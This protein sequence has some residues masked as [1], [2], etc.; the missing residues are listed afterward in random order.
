M[1][2]PIDRF[3]AVAHLRSLLHAAAR[4]VR[5]F[6]LICLVAGA[7]EPAQ[8]VTLHWLSHNAPALPT[9][10]S[11]GV[12]WPRG[13][14]SKNQAFTLTTASD[15]VLPLQSWTLAYWPDGSI[16][17]TG[18]ATCVPTGTTETL[19]LAPANQAA[20]ATPSEAAPAGPTVQV[21]ESATTYQIN[22][23]PLQAIIDKWGG[24]IVR[25]LSVNGHVVARNGRLVCIL[26]DGPADDPARAVSRQEYIS[27]VTKVTLEQSGPVRAVLKLAGVHQAEDGARQWLP[28]DV[29]LY[30]YA[31]QTT[32]RMVHT[33]TYDGNPQQD[34]IRGLAVTFAVPFR[35]ET[36][37]RQVRFSG[38]GMGL[39]SEPVQP[40]VGR[41]DHFVA[42]PGH[43]E[44]FNRREDYFPDQVAGKR[45]PNL[46]QFTE[47][48]NTAPT[49]YN[50]G[51]GQ[52]PDRRAKDLLADWT[53]WD[54]YKLTQ[55][56]ADGFTIVKRTNPQSCWL[57]AGA[58]RRASGLVFVGDVS[59]GLGVS[60][61]H[62]WQAYPSS[63]EVEKASSGEAQLTVWLWSPEAP[64]MDMRHYDTKAHGMSSLY[65][66]VQEGFST[67]EGVARTSELTL[68]PT[69]DISTK[70]D[71]AHMAEAGAQPPL[72][73]CTPE[74]LHS[75]GVFGIWSLPDRSTPF[76][77]AVEEHLDSL[78]SYYETQVEER[79]W[80]GF[81]DFGDIMHQ[82]EP[83][84]HVWC[85]DLGGM[86]WDNTELGSP[87]WLWY[88]F[89]RT[90]RADIFRMAAAMTRHNSEVD[91]YHLGHFKGLGSR[92]N[93][94]HW[95]DGAK[96]V[97]ISQAAFD[98]F[99]Y[100]L[101]TDERLGDIMHMEADSAAQAIARLDPL[102]VQTPIT[103]NESA[104]AP[105][106][107]RLGPDWFA[108]V[109][110][111]MAEWER[112]NNPKWRDLIFA[113]VNS[114]EKMP[115]GLRSGRSFVFGFDPATGKLSQPSEGVGAYG[116]A[117]IMGGAEVIFELNPLLD[118]PVWDKLW[119]Q[120]CRLC[121]TPQGVS[122]EQM[123]EIIRKDMN[124]GTEG[125]DGKYL[126]TGLS[127]P[128]LAA[129]AYLKTG[130]PVFAK[131]AIELEFPWMDDGPLKTDEVKGPDVLNPI[132]E[133]PYVCTN[134]TAQ[135]CLNAIEVLQM[136]AD[137][138]PTEPLPPSPPP[139]WMLDGLWGRPP[140]E[141]TP[142]AVRGG[143]AR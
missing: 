139:A 9:G 18:F 62:F 121:P 100:Y 47:S 56:N 8:P 68:Y 76:K 110:N 141:S 73:V 64:A 52:A 89:L 95:G 120:Y 109:G 114:L 128:C 3:R 131:R 67:P 22:T 87:M 79:N 40:M 53:V 19:T 38:E 103:S 82:Y 118:D 93:V 107:L 115:F 137:R 117:T 23:G 50:A 58:G 92:H 2:H 1:S 125:A 65:E 74:Y 97:R 55:P 112:T 31:G 24:G 135:G 32:I 61:E 101:T 133:S 21:A 78:I 14:V 136:C 134:G 29:R 30:F 75:T 108:L 54:G 37:N 28:F 46:D 45:V 15:Q 124:T 35:E 69:G 86:A 123:K 94:R 105:A 80:Y 11:W 49:T 4:F 36:Q 7:A 98:R 72:L 81:W 85:Y 66:S 51:L 5:P 111:W 70:E 59:G 129:Y 10:V 113:G 88:S 25:S 96:E 140:P 48:P 41:P 77:R 20:S 57:A 130:N 83:V 119:L 132:V 42:K 116:L 142:P 106:H 16:K 138:L 122:E 44:P 63:L 43:G 126:D 27:T 90:G 71:S 17:W 84:R 127:G 34:F 13:A 39:W 33:I 12:P 104:I 91:T 6:P 60:L 26:Q 102:R 143:P 99:D